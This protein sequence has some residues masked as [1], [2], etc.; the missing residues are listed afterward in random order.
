MK[1]VNLTPHPVHLIRD[2]GT[3]TTIQPEPVPARVATTTREVGDIDGVPIVEERY[4]EV[5]GLPDPKPGVVYVVSRVVAAARPERRDLLVP[6]DLVRDDQ[7]QVVG[8]RA[9]AQ[10][11]TPPALSEVPHL[12]GV[13]YLLALG[14]SPLQ[15]SV[16]ATR[17]SDGRWVARLHAPRERSRKATGLTQA[18]ATAAVTEM[19]SEAAEAISGSGE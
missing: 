15:A 3:T 19:L 12:V 1:L 5:A 16:S 4:E 13:E 6:A 18:Q 14:D 10:P 9:L 8:A 11:F 2:D 17:Y 7:D